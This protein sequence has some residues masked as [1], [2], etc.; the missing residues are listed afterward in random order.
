[1][2]DIVA[3]GPPLAGADDREI[4]PKATC[5]RIETLA[6]DVLEAL[7]GATY[8]RE[9]TQHL[10]RANLGIE[11]LRFPLLTKGKVSPRFC[12]GAGVSLWPIAEMAAT[13]QPVRLLG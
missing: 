8:T 10:R 2:A 7:I 11:K 5:N 1:V 6:L 12:C 13:G 4:P 9:R 3:T